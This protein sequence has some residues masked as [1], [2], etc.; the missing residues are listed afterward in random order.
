MSIQTTRTVTSQSHTE[1]ASNPGGAEARRWLS[2]AVLLV[3]NFV[4]I[5]DLFIVNVALGSIQKE[6]HASPADV[7][8]FM[9]GYSA[10]YGVMLLNGARLGDLYGRRRIFLLGMALFTAAST[11]CSLSPTPTW[12][13]AARALQGIGAALLMPQVFASLRV[14]FEGDE[15]RRAFG[16]M[17]AVQGVAASISQL[18]GGFLIEHGIAGLGWR[19]VFLVNL[20]I[21]LAALVAGRLLIVETRAP[22]P[23]KLD[24]HDAVIGAFGL[25]LLLVPFMEGQDYGWPWWSVVLPLISVPVFGYFLSYERRLSARGGVPI[26]DVALFRNHRFVAGV[27]AI[28]LFYS[29]ISSFFLSLIMLLQPGLGLRR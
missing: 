18:V 22:V 27:I 14:L 12:L 4:T 25:A 15:R 19:W 24:L 9:V 6:L 11:L 3:G 21:G 8:L 7:A 28:F 17:G 2:M 5:L 20:P 29:A 16:I 10:P 23:A 26:I 13:I 1:P